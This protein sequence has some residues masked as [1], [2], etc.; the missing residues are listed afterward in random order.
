MDFTFSA[1]GPTVTMV[2]PASVM[3]G[4]AVSSHTSGVPAQSIIDNV[5]IVN[6]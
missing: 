5:E 6:I 1:L 3:V 4:L 2:V